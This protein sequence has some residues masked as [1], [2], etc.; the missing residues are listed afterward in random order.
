MHPTLQTVIVLSVFGTQ[1]SIHSFGIS[2]KTCPCRK[3]KVI[4]VQKKIYYT[5]NP[6]N[7]DDFIFG[8]NKY[9]VKNLIEKDYSYGTHCVYNILHFFQDMYENGYTVLLRICKDG[10]FPLFTL[11]ALKQAIYDLLRGNMRFN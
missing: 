1:V 11:L 8:L 4:P 7:I 10:I 9:K 2:G 6:A 3:L 5:R